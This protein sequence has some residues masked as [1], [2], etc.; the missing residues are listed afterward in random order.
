MSITNE[1]PSDVIIAAF[2]AHADEVALERFMDAL[3]A[4]I[5]S[6]EEP[7]DKKARLMLS[8]VLADNAKDVILNLCGWTPYSLLKKARLVPDVDGQ[9]HNRIEEAEFVSIWNDET[10]EIV[11]KCKVNMETF[12]VFDIEQSDSYEVEVC[13]GEYVRF[14][15]DPEQQYPVFR[16]E[17]LQEPIIN[18]W[19]DD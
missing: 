1:Y 6:D 15:K 12:E 11:T 18:F 9:F 14:N 5:Q 19:Y 4:E 8:A 7:F 3:Y 13:D 17:E 10:T 16:K 2:L